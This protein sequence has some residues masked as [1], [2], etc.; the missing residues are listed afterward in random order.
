MEKNLQKIS[1]KSG[2]RQDWPL[3]L[4]L[5]NI[6]HEV[7]CVGLQLTPIDWCICFYANTMGFL[8]VCLFYYYSSV[9]QLEI[10]DA[11]NTSSSFIAQ[12]CFSWFCFLFVFTYKVETCPFKVCIDRAIRQLF[13][14]FLDWFTNIL[15]S[16][17]TSMFISE[18]GLY[19][20]SLLSL[21][22]FWVKG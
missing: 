4:Y 22:V 10:R 5:V 18:I 12:D 11:N 17:F 7:L 14:V 15:L 20:L 13:D 9:V 3:S 16:M 8:F 1:L 19:S 6:V 2:T 21:C